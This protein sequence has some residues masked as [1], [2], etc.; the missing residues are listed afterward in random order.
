MIDYEDPSLL[1][2]TKE[3]RAIYRII[4]YEWINRDDDEAM[5]VANKISEFVN[6]HGETDAEI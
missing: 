1:L 2:D 5:S 3:V 6:K 4:K